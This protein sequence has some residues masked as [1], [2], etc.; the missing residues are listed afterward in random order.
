[1]GKSLRGLFSM[2][3]LTRNSSVS[4]PVNRVIYSPIDRET[5]RKAQETVS[6]IAYE[7]ME[8]G[9]YREHGENG[10]L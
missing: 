10:L 4:R 6:R 1:M 8:K 2:E 7:L 3:R 5:Q 9:N